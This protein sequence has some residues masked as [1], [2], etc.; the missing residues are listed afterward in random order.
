MS[1]R[2]QA[3]DQALADFARS[4]DEDQAIF[5]ELCTTGL[6]QIAEDTHEILIGA[7]PVDTGLLKASWIVSLDERA[8]KSQA[9]KRKR[10]KKSKR[11]TVLFSSD[12]AATESRKSQ[13][14]LDNL[15]SP[16]TDVFITNPQNY[17][18]FVDV[19]N[20]EQRGRSPNRRADSEDSGDGGVKAYNMTQLAVAQMRE[21]AYVVGDRDAD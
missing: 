2:S 6:A 17:A 18:S 11:G 10:G 3:Q 1:Q 14:V 9:P 19:G 5:L 4:L 7:T 16:F 13:S 12:A 8:K 15:A 20:D 21:R